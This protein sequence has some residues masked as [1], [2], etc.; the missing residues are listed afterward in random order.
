MLRSKNLMAN[1]LMMR[2]SK[3]VGHGG[4]SCKPNEGICRRHPKHRQSPGVCSLCL[5]E[6]LSQLS[7]HSNYSRSSTTTG[8]SSDCSSSA[9]SFSSYYSSSDASYSSPMHRYRFTSE[10]RSSSFSLL[11]L[12]GKNMLT[13]SRS[14]AFAAPRMRSK[15]DGDD[16][17]KKNK[18]DG[19]LSK[20]LH[21]KAK[22]SNKR[23]EQ[24]PSGLVHSRTMRE[25]LSTSRVH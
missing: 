9:S 10:G 21:P 4:P 23:K 25:V 24:E 20:L 6:K 15:L 12:S 13:K 8:A 16:H 2:R 17:H 1:H 14:V 7:A 19:F 11:L 22:G 3:D 5:G 18:K